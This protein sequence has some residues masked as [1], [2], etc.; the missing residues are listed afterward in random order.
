VKLTPTFYIARMSH[1]DIFKTPF[2]EWIL[3]W[4][5]KQYFSPYR[6]QTSDWVTMDFKVHNN[7]N[8]SRFVIMVLNLDEV[9]WIGCCWNTYI[10]YLYGFQKCPLRSYLS[11]CKSPCIVPKKLCIMLY[12][13]NAH[14]I[15]LNNK[16]K[17][18]AF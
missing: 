3:T 13:W 7:K 1:Y 5:H 11:N 12:P 8:M 15:F 6:L 2:V 18:D 4:S 9:N 16:L 10:Q 14:W 17:M